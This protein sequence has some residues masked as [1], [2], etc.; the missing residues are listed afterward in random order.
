MCWIK[1]QCPT[2]DT[3]SAIEIPAG[4]HAASHSYGLSGVTW[5]SKKANSFVHHESSTAFSC[6]EHY[7]YDKQQIRC[8]REVHAAHRAIYSPDVGNRNRRP[9]LCTGTRS[10][11]ALNLNDSL[12]P[13]VERSDERIP[14]NLGN[15]STA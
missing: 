5:I 10:K 7:I 6:A 1:I 3:L 4:A 14:P 13:P 9:V 15:K 12:R 2:E 11:F 8:Q